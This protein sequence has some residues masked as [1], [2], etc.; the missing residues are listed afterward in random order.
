MIKNFLVLIFAVAL[1][2]TLSAQ[3]TSSDLKKKQSEIQ[4]EIDDL[5]RSLDETKKYKKEGLAQYNLVQKKIRLRENQI[6][7]I[8]QQINYIQGDINQSSREISKLH[9]ELDTLKM[10]YEKSVVYSYKNRSNYD[11]L[12]FIFSAG[13]FN[14]ALK[15]V[16]YLKSYRNYREEQAD[17]IQRTQQQLHQ[18]IASLN[19]NKIKKSEVLQEQSKQMK[20][21]E[22]DKKEKEAVVSKLKSRE[23]E[24][25]KDMNDKRKQDLSLRSAI[26]AA[27]NREITK[28]REKQRL[29]DIEASK[30]E[31]SKEVKT[32]T[33]SSGNVAAIKRPSSGVSKTPSLFDNRAEIKALSDN[34][35]KNR[36]NLP[37]PISS[38]N[39][40]M[41]FGRQTYVEGV[42]IILDNP[43]ITIESS[44]GSSVKAVFDGEVSAIINVGPVQGVIL[45]HGKY[46]TTYS[47]LGSVSVS[48]GQQV[49]MGQLLGKLEEKDEGRGELEFLITNDK[50]QNENP[51][52]WLR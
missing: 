32:E 8:N 21:L 15:R 24:I 30:K 23:K 40:S 41:H 9:R 31:A 38:G 25:T 7:N 48:K 51:E 44:A 36:G 39:I 18:K 17:N 42:K 27:I 10:Q 37:W 16:A 6:N 20:V 14:D 50:N 12:N 43:G 11:F 13:S 22:E 33:V 3:Q 5:R 4:K 26:K 29:A 35:E 47:N 28:E 19:E 46:F 2:G 49:K 52:R 34:F 45:K 1:A